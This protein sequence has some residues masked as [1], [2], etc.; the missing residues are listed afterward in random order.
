MSK[1]EDLRYMQ[2]FGDMK[3]ES[4]VIKA[5]KSDATKTLN[6]VKKQLNRVSCR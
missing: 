3:L 4:E 5:G 2:I 6:R 1:I